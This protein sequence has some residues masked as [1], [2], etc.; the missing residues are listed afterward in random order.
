MSDDELCASKDNTSVLK[1]S[2]TKIY[3]LWVFSLKNV[4]FEKNRKTTC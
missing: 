2:G 3:L 1:V 4:L